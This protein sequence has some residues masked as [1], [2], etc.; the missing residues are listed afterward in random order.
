MGKQDDHNRGQKDGSE[1]SRFD[2]LVED[3]NPFCSQE[4]K[5]GFRHGFA[6]RPEK[7][8]KIEWPRREAERK[9][10]RTRNHDR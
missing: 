5:E 8:F 6:K 3:F 1:A 4:Y 7:E 2:Y 10:A 9:E